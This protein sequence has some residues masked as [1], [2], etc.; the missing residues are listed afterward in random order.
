[1]DPVEVDQRRGGTSMLAALPAVFV[2]YAVAAHDFVSLGV[3]GICA[4]L[5]V[6]QGYLDAASLYLRIVLM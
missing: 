5:G 1:M 3:V 4:N 6:L 2:H